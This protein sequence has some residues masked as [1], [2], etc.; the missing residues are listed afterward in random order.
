MAAKY[1]STICLPDYHCRKKGD[2]RYRSYFRAGTNETPLF[3]DI[4]S[5][6][7]QARLNFGSKN[8][9]GSLGTSTQKGFAVR[10]VYRPLSVNS[11]ETLSRYENNENVRA[12]LGYIKKKWQKQNTA[13]QPVNRRR[14]FPNKSNRSA[15]RSSKARRKVRA[16]L[17]T[18]SDIMLAKM[19]VPHSV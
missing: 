6:E 13:Q 17:L 1:T 11:R 3:V 5:R 19:P 7:S 14:S 18:A 15:L 8:V 9:N 4:C 12:L 10:K 16:E 2:N